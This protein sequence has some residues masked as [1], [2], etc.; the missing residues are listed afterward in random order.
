MFIPSA[1]IVNVWVD[2]DTNHRSTTTGISYNGNLVTNISVVFANSAFSLYKNGVFLQT[3]STP[4]SSIYSTTTQFRLATDGGG[5]G[6]FSG[7]IYSAKMYN[8]ALTAAEISQNY[9]QAPIVTNG[10]VLAVDAGNVISYENGS[11]T[12]YSLTGSLSGSLIN[13]TG[14]TNNNGGVWDLDGSDDRIILGFQ[15]T[16][17]TSDITQEAWVNADSMT[18]WS[19]IISNMPS[20]G[21][22]FS[23]Q[24]GPIQNIAAMVSGEYLT[25]SWAPHTGVWYHILATHRSSDD[26]NVLYVNGVQENSFIKSISYSANA[27]TEIGV[28]YTGGGLPIDGKIGLVRTYNRALTAAEVSQNFNAQR[29]RFGI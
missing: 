2:T 20:W 16:M 17:L 5:T 25:T 10:L 6:F 4:S 1:N 27:V 18:N 26:L 8:R 19:G 9:Y 22:G 29:N 21:T 13:G 28:F 11:T 3:V 12:T 24:I 7:S 14:F 23:L 15:P